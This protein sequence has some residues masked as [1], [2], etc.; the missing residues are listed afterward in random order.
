MVNH[1]RLSKALMLM[2]RYVYDMLAILDGLF[3]AIPGL[4]LKH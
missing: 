3:L 4:A 2:V 1:V